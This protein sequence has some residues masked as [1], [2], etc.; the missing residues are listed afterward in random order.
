MRSPTGN[1]RATKADQIAELQDSECIHV[2]FKIQQLCLELWVDL[3]TSPA[4]ATP[5]IDA[6]ALILQDLDYLAVVQLVIPELRDGEPLPSDQLQ[7]QF[8]QAVASTRADLKRIRHTHQ[9]DFDR[10]VPFYEDEKRIFQ[11]AELYRAGLLLFNSGCLDKHE[12]EDVWEWLNNCPVRT[13]WQPVQDHQVPTG[14]ASREV[15]SAYMAS[16]LY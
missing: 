7:R 8:V 5:Y 2:G 4:E 10:Q 1:S 14:T 9:A 11:E 12:R 13:T 15:S 3:K 6:V 16:F